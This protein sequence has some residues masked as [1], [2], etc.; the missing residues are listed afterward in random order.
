MRSS[1]DLTIFETYKRFK[2][3]IDKS[4]AVVT[5]RG[6]ERQDFKER[7]MGFFL[8]VAE[9]NGILWQE[10]LNREVDYKIFP[11]SPSYPALFG[12]NLASIA[13]N[14]LSGFLNSQVSEFQQYSNRSFLKF[15]N[16]AI[17]NVIP[18]NMIERDEK[19]LTAIRSWIVDYRAHLYRLF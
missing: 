2:N 3:Y 8:S 16:Y 17:D 14:E 6:V 13:D 12:M 5:W 15:M 18:F 10:I 9:A 4:N 19:R 7:E 11:E 1:F